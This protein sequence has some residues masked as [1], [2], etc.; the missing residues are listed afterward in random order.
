[1]SNCSDPYIRRS[2]G[3]NLD[4][5]RLSSRGWDGH[6]LPADEC[7]S[8]LSSMTLRVHV[9]KYGILG[10]Q[11]TCYIGTLGPKC[12]IIRYMDP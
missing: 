11:S 5:S 8:T 10:P 4:P 7:V 2:Q 6:T 3:S 12:K 1:M 9:P